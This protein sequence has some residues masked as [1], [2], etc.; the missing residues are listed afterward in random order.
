[1]PSGSAQ[2]A[3]PIGPVSISASG[4]A[5]RVAAD[6]DGAVMWFESADLP[7]AAAPEA[8][9]S[10]ALIPALHH[11]RRLRIADPVDAEWLANLG[12]MM[13]LLHRWWR[14]PALLPEAVPRANASPPDAR[15]RGPIALFFSGGVDSF[16]RLLK[17]EERPDWIVTLWGFDFALADDTRGAAVVESVRRVAAATG[18]RSAVVRTNAREHPLVARAPWER[19]HGGI[20]AA[21]GHLLAPATTR[22]IISCST[23]SDLEIPYG[24]HWSIDPLWSSSR[25]AILHGGR[26]GRRMEKLREIAPHPLVR[27]HL[28]VC[29]RNLAPTG[30]CSRCLKCLYAMLVLESCGELEHSRAFAGREELIAGLDALPRV[31]D[32]LEEFAALAESPGLDPRVAA[33]ARALVRRGRHAARP[34]VRLRRAVVRWLFTRLGLTGRR[35]SS[36]RAK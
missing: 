14:Y 1:M 32:R 34:D 16:H 12:R 11:G 23:P 33:A 5:C 7:L 8:F 24:S 22:V 3:V 17:G 18:T 36:A 13:P 30:N 28:R 31:R 25:T 2:D 35:K 6:V 20:L 9:G 26:G 29:W 4:A 19:A 15:D 10:A 27:E 21:I